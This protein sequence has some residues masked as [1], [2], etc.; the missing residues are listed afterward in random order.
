MSEAVEGKHPLAN[1]TLPI[2]KFLP[3]VGKSQSDPSMLTTL[4]RVCS[5]SRQHFARWSGRQPTRI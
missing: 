5:R 4:K 1:P 3:R 2:G